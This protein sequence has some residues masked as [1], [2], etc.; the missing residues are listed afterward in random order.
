MKLVWDF[1][2][3]QSLQHHQADD[4]GVWWGRPVKSAHESVGKISICPTHLETI[5]GNYDM[6]SLL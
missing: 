4:G 5:S 2:L 3:M 6:I 1:C